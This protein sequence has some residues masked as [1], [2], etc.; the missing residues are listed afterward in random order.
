MKDK[1]LDS[2]LNLFFLPNPSEQA[3]EDLTFR[4][5]N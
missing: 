2:Y 4:F 5:V 1:Y 3:S